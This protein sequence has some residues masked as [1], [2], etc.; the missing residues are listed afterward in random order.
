MWCDGMWWDVMGWD[1][2]GWDVSRKCSKYIINPV[3]N[4][5]RFGTFYHCSSLDYRLKQRHSP[6]ENA[7]NVLFSIICSKPC[8]KGYA[9]QF[10]ESLSRQMQWSLSKNE[11]S[12]RCSHSSSCL[13]FR[14]SSYVTATVITIEKLGISFDMRR[15][16]SFVC[17][18]MICLASQLIKGNIIFR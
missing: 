1:G 6:I 11:V 17:G 8:G 14:N 4:Y 13:P 15:R 9:S 2:M 18:K 16:A 12:N 3:H 5:C 7:C 10:K